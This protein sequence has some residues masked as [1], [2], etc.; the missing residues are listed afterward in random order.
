MECLYNLLQTLKNDEDV[1]K[2]AVA[3][4]GLALQF[5]SVKL[6]DNT[7]VVKI[8]VDNDKSALQFASQRIINIL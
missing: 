6:K 3:N 5:A 8:A 7:D 2:I 1:V 4:Y